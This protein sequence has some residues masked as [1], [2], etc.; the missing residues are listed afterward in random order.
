MEAAEE[1]PGISDM[2]LVVAVA[3]GAV[4][5]VQVSPNSWL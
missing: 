2:R 1:A 3:I 5:V 4:K